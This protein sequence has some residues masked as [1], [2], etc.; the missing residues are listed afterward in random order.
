MPDYQLTKIYYIP[1]GD[2]RY[3]GHTA[4]KYL[5][6]RQTVHQMEFRYALNNNKVTRKVHKALVEA[7]MTANQIECVFVENYPCECIEE[8][9]ARERWWIENHATLNMYIPTR[10]QMEY[11]EQ[12]K[13]KIVERQKKYYERNQDK[14]VEYNKQNK[15]K[16]VEYQK[17]YNEQNKDKIAEIHKKYYE[18]NKDKF[19]LYRE[20]NKDKIAE[21]RKQNKDKKNK[22]MKEYNE[23]NKDK[24]AEYQ[25]AYREQNKDKNAEYQKVY[26]ERNKDKIAE[27]RA[28]KASK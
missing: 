3:Y 13:G 23:R 27:N 17:K 25:K 19:A 9:K 21:Y 26:R 28:R 14:I 22:Y 10:T 7:G 20:Q 5:S 11:Y 15:D 2:E 1:V 12:N 6:S 18:R 4:Q 16:I 24:N 8:A